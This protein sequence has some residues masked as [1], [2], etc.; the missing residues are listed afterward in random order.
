MQSNWNECFSS[1]GSLKCP[2][3]YVRDVFYTWGHMIENLEMPQNRKYSCSVLFPFWNWSRV[4]FSES[5]TLLYSNILK[6][7]IFRQ[8]QTG[9]P[10]IKNPR[11][12]IIS[13]LTNSCI[14]ICTFFR[15]GSVRSKP[16]HLLLLTKM[17]NL[18]W[19]PL[20]LCFLDYYRP[21]M[22]N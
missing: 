21:W 4:F 1:R 3:K 9:P 13:I 16:N 15:L 14:V 8:N 18:Y 20:W 2:K 17:A 5:H 7:P 12:L 6:C 22:S 19:W 10:H 11:D